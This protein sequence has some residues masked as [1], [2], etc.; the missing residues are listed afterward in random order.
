MCYIIVI[1]F[2]VYHH[3]IKQL[4][5]IPDQDISSTILQSL[6]FFFSLLFIFFGDGDG[7]IRFSFLNNVAFI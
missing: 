1:F 5:S 3:Y 2:H 6:V 4:K 7:G